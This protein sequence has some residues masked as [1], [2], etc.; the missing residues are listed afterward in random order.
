[1]KL[2]VLHTLSLRA[3]RGNLAPTTLS[4]S[5]LLRRNDRRLPQPSTHFLVGSGATKQSQWLTRNEARYLKR[6]S[7]PPRKR[8]SGAC[9]WPEQGPTVRTLRPPVQARG[10]L[11]VP[12]V[13]GMTDKP[14]ILRKSLWFG[15]SPRP[16]PNPCRH[17]RVRGSSTVTV[18]CSV[19]CG[20]AVI[21][22]TPFGA[23]KRCH[24]PCGTITTIPAAS[25]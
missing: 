1:M 3:E 10:R 16:R 13:A 19:G 9:P 5:R 20:V 22:L 21:R 6:L 8:G 14:L 25:A 17:S 7:S 23:S 18:R 4:R 24:A 12:A 11:W 2:S 15:L